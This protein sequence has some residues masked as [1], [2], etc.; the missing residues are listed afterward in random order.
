MARPKH[1]AH[2]KPPM[3]HGA[4]PWALAVTGMVLILAAAL[5]FVLAAAQ[6]DQTA[7]PTV[8]FGLPFVPS[9]KMP[10]PPTIPR[11]G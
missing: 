10:S 6:G 11:G 3:S 5:A 7:Q 9:F 4:A 1:S 8:R 2:D